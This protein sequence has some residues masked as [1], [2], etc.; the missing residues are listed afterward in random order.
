MNYKWNLD[1]LYSGFEDESFTADTK[2]LDSHIE[3]LVSLS[4]RAG[5]MDPLSLIREFLSV[6]NDLTLVT[7]KLFIYANLRYSANT[8]DSDAAS[9]MGV[10]M[11][12]MSATAA[13][14]AA[15]NKKIAGIENLAE[16][17]ADN[18]DLH[19]Y[20]FYLASIKEES[21][22]L[23]TDAEES[24]FAEMNISGASAWSDLQSS[25][26]STLKVDYNGE[27]LALNTDDGN[28]DIGTEF[29]EG[30]VF[31]KLHI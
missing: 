17:I 30:T 10:L 20:E 22:H 12:K 31:C 19:E 14:S 15:L 6:Q 7:S 25:L 11:G 24:L 18:K 23:L 4:E 28:R 9:I 16:L 26:T 21:K 1:I 29:G 27:H 8:A 13:P 2:L 5:E 3:R